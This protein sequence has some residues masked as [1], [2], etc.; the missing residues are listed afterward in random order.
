MR[1]LFTSTPGLGHFYPLVPLARAARAA[2]DEVRI[3]IG[4]EGL[5]SVTDLGFDAV[6][7]AEPAPQELGRFW[8]ALDGQ[9]EP[10]TYVIGGLFAR[11]RARAA[12]A[13]TRTAIEQ[14]QPDLVVSEVAEFAGQ[15]AAEL[16]GVRHVSV[17]ISSMGLPDLTHQVIA[18]E[19]DT[20][21]AEVGLPTTGDVP[22]K[23]STT[24]FVTPVPRFMWRSADDVPADTTVY[25]HEDPE[26]PLPAGVPAPRA[27]TG[28]P[29]VY[30]TLGSVAGTM[31]FATPAFG[32]MLAGLG[33]LDA[34]VL[35]TIGRL[36][37]ASLGPVPANVHVESFLPQQVAM[38][39]DAVVCH[40]GAGTTMAAL[41]RGLPTVVVPLFA[42]QMHN[43]ARVAATGAGLVVDPREMATSLTPAVEQVLTDGSF[44]ATARSI[45]RDLA[46]LPSAADVL[47]AVRPVE[48]H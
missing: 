12:L 37:R 44:A 30:A 8:A 39:C 32:A 18:D 21:R 3:A 9:P 20:L 4:P 11:L 27:R 1:V 15:M 10:N 46:A 17:G 48:V 5:T 23:H 42:D 26:G 40:G 16:A 2:G 29:K 35:F 14:L 22:W 47:A 33:R 25:R 6:P 41:T 19:V 34:D 36:D 45:A 38:A 7:T 31:D 24:R 28:R 43:A 13:A